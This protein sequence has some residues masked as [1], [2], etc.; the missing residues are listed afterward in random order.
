MHDIHMGPAKTNIILGGGT[1]T[2]TIKMFKI[3]G[4]APT[5]NYVHISDKA[6]VLPQ[7]FILLLF[8]VKP[9]CKKKSL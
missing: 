8:I 2:I 1:C 4:I 7:F 6:K 5:R 3:F 9:F